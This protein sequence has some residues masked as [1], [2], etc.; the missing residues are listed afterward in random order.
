MLPPRFSHPTSTSFGISEPVVS[1]LVPHHI[2]F[3]SIPFPTR[4]SLC[5]GP[6]QCVSLDSNL[7]A[8]RQPAFVFCLRGRSTLVPFL[9]AAH[10]VASKPSVCPRLTCFLSMPCPYCSTAP[11]SPQR[12][13]RTFTGL[14]FS[15]RSAQ[16]LAPQWRAKCF[17]QGDPRCAPPPP[18][19]RS[20]SAVLYMNPYCRLGASCRSDCDGR[21][22]FPRENSKFTP[23]NAHTHRHMRAP[24]GPAMVNLPP[25]PLSGCG[26]YAPSHT[27]G[28]GLCAIRSYH[29]GLLC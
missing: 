6:F 19:P 22:P 9:F 4:L 10:T 21:R 8:H 15:V 28:Q 1:P 16:Q 7:P 11:L 23:A 29:T 5:C 17:S 3:H 25:W 14:P 27:K 12:M 26:P 2:P 18:P 24:L 20:P 13:L